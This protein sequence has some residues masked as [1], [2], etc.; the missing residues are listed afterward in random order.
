VDFLHVELVYAL[1]SVKDSCVVLD[2]VNMMETTP[3][4][5]SNTSVYISS[6]LLITSGSVCVCVRS[7]QMQPVLS[8]AKGSG[9]GRVSDGQIAQCK[10]L[11][12]NSLI[13]RFMCQRLDLFTIFP[14]S[15]RPLPIC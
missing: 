11:A 1:L 10:R 15:N 3:G 14:V 4:L 6:L 12:D 5:R 7:Y 9:W 8:E 13:C 2:V